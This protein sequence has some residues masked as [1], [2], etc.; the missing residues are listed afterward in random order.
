MQPGG[1]VAFGP[2]APADVSEPCP[3]WLAAHPEFCTVP[4]GQDPGASLD[5]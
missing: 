1:R 5:E 4:V 2:P 3:Q